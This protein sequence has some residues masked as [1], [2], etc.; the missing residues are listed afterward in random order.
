MWH[1]KHSNKV[2]VL[3]VVLSAI[4]S[5]TAAAATEP[6]SSPI[7][8]KSIFAPVSTPAKS[9]FDLSIFVLIVTASIFLAV[10]SLLAYAVVKFRKRQ[11]DGG[12]EPAQ[13]YGCTQVER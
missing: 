11:S 13:V 7:S 8:P 2:G 10:F 6:A 5:A 3:Q 4:S 1:T 12:L 9:I